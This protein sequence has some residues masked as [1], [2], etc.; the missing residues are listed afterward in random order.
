MARNIAR[1]RLARRS[2]DD[3]RWRGNTV[4]L[5]YRGTGGAR[6]SYSPTVIQARRGSLEVSML[7]PLRVGLP[8]DIETPAEVHGQAAAGRDRAGAPSR[9]IRA[10][11]TGCRCNPDGLFRIC[12]TYQDPW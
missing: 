7:V 2:S 11:V 10:Q 1:S 8:V 12:L 6:W 5:A 4:R 9:S 3:A